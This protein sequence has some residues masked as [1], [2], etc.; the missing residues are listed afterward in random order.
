MASKKSVIICVVLAYM[1]GE[2]F[3]MVHKLGPKFEEL[4][5]FCSLNEYAIFR[6]E[7][8]A[9]KESENERTYMSNEFREG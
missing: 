6:L 4:Y 7:N 1:F 8:H 9:W 5:T 3:I 2:R